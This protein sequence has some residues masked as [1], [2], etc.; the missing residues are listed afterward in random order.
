MTIHKGD[1]AE[2]CWT[3]LPGELRTRVFE[4]L[5]ESYND[6]TS[7]SKPQKHERAAYAAVSRQ[8]QRFFEPDN[9]ER[10]ILHQSDVA[11]LGKIVQGQRRTY[12]RWIWLRLVLPEYSCDKCDTKETPQELAS[13]DSLFTDALWD[14]FAILCVWGKNGKVQAAKGG[15]T[16]ELSAHSPSDAE[17]CFKELQ[18]RIDD[19]AWSVGNTGPRQQYEDAAHGWK[20][21]L[22][23]RPGNLAKLRVFGPPGGLGFSLLAP[24]ARRMGKLPKVGVVGT[25]VIRRQFYRHI[26]VTEALFPMF[27]SLT[28]L[29]QFAYEPWSGVDMSGISGRAIR[30]EQHHVLFSEAFRYRKSLRIVSIFEDRHTPVYIEY[31]EWEASIALGQDL[32]RSSRRFEELYVADN[33]DAIGFFHAFRPGQHL[34]M[35]RGLRWT[36]LKYLC[37][38]SRLLCPTQ[39]D[40]LIQTA[41][42]AALKMQKLELMELWNT[43]RWHLCVFRY[44]RPPGRPP[45]IQL[46]S[47]WG[48]QLGAQAVARWRL[49]AHGQNSREELEVESKCLG[50]EIFKVKGSVFDYLASRDRVLGKTSLRQLLSGPRTG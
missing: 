33:V 36:N 7:N 20:G 44:E 47:T 38:S 27:K 12:V 8:W 22:I 26:S 4:V 11:E 17:H 6:H 2:S 13:H 14:L 9:F 3:S 46:I 10:L 40:N 39:Y 42:A 21:K 18:C 50:L 30:D 43:G 34:N 41:A 49:V 32:A 1:P 31:R 24:S 28:K 35:T 23:R 29:R 15:L 16:L 37:L 25:L 19:T 45:K 48:G 5:Q